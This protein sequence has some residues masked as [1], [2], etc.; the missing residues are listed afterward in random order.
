M[1]PIGLPY[2][3]STSVGDIEND[4]L[5]GNLVTGGGGGVGGD[6]SC[7]GGGGGGGGSG[8]GGG[9]G[10]GGGGGVGLDIP[11]IPYKLINQHY[12]FERT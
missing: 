10:G 5:L 11:L 9:G 1:P 2:F 7:D 8:D 4:P 6:D 12:Y 3:T